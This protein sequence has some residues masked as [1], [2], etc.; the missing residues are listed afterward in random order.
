MLVHTQIGA[1]LSL[2]NLQYL[3]VFAEYLLGR[4]REYAEQQVLL[5]RKLELPLLKSLGDRTDEQLILLAVETSREFLTYLAKNK[6]EEQIEQSLIR[7]IKNQLPHIDQK[8]IIAEDI[9]LMNYIRKQNFLYFINDYTKDPRQILALIQ[10]IDMFLTRSETESANTYIDLLRNRIREQSYLNEKITNTSPG[11]IYLFNIETR[12]ISFANQTA[13]EFFGLKNT[14]IIALGNTVLQHLIYTDDIEPTLN[15]LNEISG[16]KEAEDWTLEFRLRN[17]EGHYLW[18]RNYISVFKRNEKG[19]PLEIIGNILNIHVEKETAQQLKQSEERYKQASRLSRIGHFTLNLITNGLYFTEELNRIYEFPPEMKHHKYEDIIRLR[20]PD[21]VRIVRENLKTAVDTRQPFDFY[22]RIITKE[23][24]EKTLHTQGGLVFDKNGSPFELVGTVQDVTERQKLIQRLQESEKLHQQAQSLAHLGNWSMNLKTLEYNWSDEMYNIY[25]LE[26]GESITAKDWESFIH[27]EDKESV[28][29]Y[30]QE[31]LQERKPYEKHHRIILRNGKIKML[32]RKG[33]LVLDEQGE[34]IKLIG[35]TQDVTEQ[36]R[37]QQELNDNQT[38]IRKIA[39]ATPSII[40]SY[41]VITGNYVFISEGLQKLLGYLPQQVLNEGISFFTNIIHPDDLGMVMQRN[42]E[43]LEAANAQPERNDMV[44]EFNYRMKNNNGKYRWFHTYGTIF[45]RNHIGMVEH[46]LNISLDVTEQ[47]EASKKIEEQEHFIQHIA[48]ASPTILY[49]FDITKN[50]FAYV[51]REIYFVLGYTPE[52]IIEMEE[53]ATKVLYHPDDINLLPERKLSTKK[54][55]ESDLMIQYECRMKTKEGEWQWFLVREVVFKTD[56]DNKILQIVGAALDISKRKDMERTLLQN[57]FQ[58]EQS[59]ASLEE[60]AYVASHDL[61][62][63]LRK[64]STFGDRL[65]ATQAEQMSPDGRIYLKKIIDASQRMQIM[66]SDLLSISMISGNKSFEKYSLQQ[67]LDETLQ[68]LEYKIE[69]KNAVIRAEPLPVANIVPPQFRQLFQN[70]LSN[71]L[72]FVREDVQPAITIRHKF[73]NAG[74]VTYYQLTAAEKYLQIEF[75][76][77]GIGFENEYAGR[78]FAIFQ[79]LHG[80]SEYEGSGIGLAICK[81]IVEH[82][83][84]II[85]ASGI[86]DEGATFTIILPA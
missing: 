76:D 85:Y 41:N 31:C 69:Q 70:L 28:L 33:E 80:R 68:T 10:E 37:I 84:G 58:L 6:A 13:E 30:F 47:V 43:A 54:I 42:A 65:V 86:P 2:T 55:A 12:S 79:R 23:G 61:K 77:N 16:T 22:Y 45:D 53:N 20:H 15:L 63:P 71:S 8:D 57:S 9:T 3:P 25:E 38:F 34:P 46:V 26:K 40:T 36:H 17:K 51:N 60:F 44:V 11:I 5:S 81:K 29:A 75:M 78:I 49:V 50:G 27:P 56:E 21:D 64:I 19:F 35:T 67:I 72:K 82:H 24:N 39:D 4:L 83:G 7:W 32:H 18:M 66:I 74:D 14:E 59:N 52:E 48:D 73:L 1:T 62:E